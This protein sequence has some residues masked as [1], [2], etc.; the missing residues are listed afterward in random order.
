MVC[1]FTVVV[2]D[3]GNRMTEADELLAGRTGR[4]GSQGGNLTRC[5][6]INL[7]CGG[8]WELGFGE[9]LEEEQ[10]AEGYEMRCLDE[11]FVG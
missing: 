6:S 4:G 11:C 8:Q 1:S 2:E 9:E 3:M 10:G 5:L 7:G